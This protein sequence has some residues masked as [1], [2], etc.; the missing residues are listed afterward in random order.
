MMETIIIKDHIKVYYERAKSFPEGILTAHQTLHSIIPFSQHRRYFGIS[1]PEGKDG[2]IVYKAAAEQLE[3]DQIKNFP[4]DT[5]MIAKG[6]YQCITVLNYAND[7]QNISKAFEE[8]TAL[9]TID[10]K[11]YC[12]EWYCNDRDVR[13]MV[14]TI[15]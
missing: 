13:C 15:E 3:E 11:G 5:F 1:R 10:P 12:I 4:L 9:S 2:V 14:R 8:L 7:P 6:T